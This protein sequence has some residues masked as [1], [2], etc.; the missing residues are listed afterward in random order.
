M[1]VVL[2]L[3][4]HVGVVVRDLDS[5]VRFFTEVVGLRFEGYEVVEEQGVK[6]AFLS[7]GNVEVEL[8]APLSSASPVAKFLEKRGEGFHHLAFRVKDLSDTLKRLKA[9]G[10]RLIDDKPRKGARGRKIVFVHPKSVYGI[11]LE[12]C[13]DEG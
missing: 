12:L 2:V 13:E 10:L 5:A 1:G 11:L 6:I 9:E 4:D 7:A 3:L 8:I